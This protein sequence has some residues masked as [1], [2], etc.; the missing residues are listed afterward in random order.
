M[1][2]K[3]LT[4]D[5]FTDLVKEIDMFKAV[6]LLD[7]Q[8]TG[9]TKIQ[10]KHSQS[11]AF[12]FTSSTSHLKASTKAYEDANKLI[13]NSHDFW[14]SAYAKLGQNAYSENPIVSINSKDG[15]DVFFRLLIK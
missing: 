7:K 3:G 15:S 10:G 8:F 11:A 12:R 4:V 6:G 5:V 13:H 14:V 2:L 9:V 1:G